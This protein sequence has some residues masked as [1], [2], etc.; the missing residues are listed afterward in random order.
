[1]RDRVCEVA[2]VADHD[3]GIDALVEQVEQHTPATL[4][5]EPFSSRRATL[6]MNRASGTGCSLASWIMIGQPLEAVR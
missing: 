2:V 1:L 6:T 3:C 5:S 4:T